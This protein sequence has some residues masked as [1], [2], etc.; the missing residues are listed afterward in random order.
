VEVLFERER[1]L[2]PLDTP[3]RRA[4]LKGRLRQAAAAISDKD[5]SQA[6]R[7]DLLQKFDALFARAPSAGAP[8]GSFGATTPRGGRGHRS[9]P[10]GA[11]SGP[12]GRYA[13]PPSPPTAEGK[14][15]AK[16]LAQAIEPVAAAVAQAAVDSP[17]L[18]DEHLEALETH[19]FG[20]PALQELAREIIRL[21]LNVDTLDSPTLVR[22]L[23][24]RGFAPLL[25]QVSDAARKSGAPFLSDG[26][27]AAESGSWSQA[28]LTLARL[29]ALDEALSAAKAHAGEGLDAQAFSRMKAER[30]ALRREVR[31]G[32]VWAGGGS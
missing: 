25:R 2:E 27:S 1:E 4:G 20:D 31:T 22:H 30:D 3:E 9:S 8:F 32:T 13:D 28:F 5:L 12:G 23:A 21:R 18:L 6:Y 16:R 10:Y 7:E 11:R 15:A 17:D 14:A 29:A 24:G 19:G 26:G